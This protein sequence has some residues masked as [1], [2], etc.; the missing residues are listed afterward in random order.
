MY[1]KIGPHHHWFQPA[2]WF[3]RWTLWRYGAGDKK[4]KDHTDND[5]VTKYEEVM[6]QLRSLTLY[7]WLQRIEQWVDSR[8][9]RR[10]KIKI[11]NYD[12]WGADHTLSMII[13]PVL[14]LLKEK[15]PGAP[16]VDDDDV[17]EE[18]RST[19]VP[20]VDEYGTDDNHFKRWDW[21]MDE[22]IWTFEQISA[23]DA[24]NQFFQYPDPDNL[25]NCVF[26][27]DGYLEY[28]NRIDRGT[29]LFGKYFRGLW[30]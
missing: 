9:K 28:Q 14:K 1:A 12:V 30:D 10:I 24:D 23:D 20:P 5:I 29:R 18:L 22:M 4:W 21:V 16:H 3:K 15:K 11:H 6:D 2:L 19:A 25:D 7:K 13:L 27:K 26:D 17:P 8:Y